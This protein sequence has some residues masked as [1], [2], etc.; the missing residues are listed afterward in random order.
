MSRLVNLDLDLVRA[1]V[2]WLIMSLG[3]LVAMIMGSRDTT[4]G[5]GS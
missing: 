3:L 4:Q 1:F 2:G 5:S